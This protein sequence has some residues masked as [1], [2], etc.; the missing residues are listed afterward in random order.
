M[1]GNDSA[2]DP[3]AGVCGK[4]GQSV[5]AALGQPTVKIAGMTVGGSAG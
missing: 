5:P 1:I 4:N 2:L 3:G